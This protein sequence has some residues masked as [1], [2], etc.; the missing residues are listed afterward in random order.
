MLANLKRGAKVLTTGGI[1]GTIVSAKDGEDE[2]VDPVRRHAAAGQAERRSSRCSAPTRPRRRKLVVNGRKRV[3]RCSG[4]S[5]RDRFGPR[6]QRGSTRAG[7]GSEH[8]A[9]EL[10]PRVA[11]LPDPVPAG[12]PVRGPAR[13]VQARHRPRRRDH[14]RLRDQPGAHQAA[15]RDAGD[16][17][18][19]QTAAGAQDPRGS[20]PRR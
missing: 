8:H 11:D 9:T 5:K 7:Q 17:P 19:G 12:R 18:Q 15:E 14:P 6:L 20:T 13:Q 10:P 16:R 4:V 3:T 2:I 1:V